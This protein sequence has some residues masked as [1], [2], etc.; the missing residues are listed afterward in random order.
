VHLACRPADEAQ[1]YRGGAAH[2]AFTR[3]GAVGC[4]VV[5]AC[6]REEP[7]PAL[8]APGVA[9]ALP[10]GRLERHPTLGHFGP[11]EAPGECAAAV[12]ALLD[13]L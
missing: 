13:A 4:P 5:V 7:G 12:V 3:L 6:G 10:G 11:L 2:D 1:I 9:D 8:F